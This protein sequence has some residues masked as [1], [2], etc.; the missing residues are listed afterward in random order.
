M[1]IAH[2]PIHPNSEWKNT[3]QDPLAA[4]REIR[5]TGITLREHYAGLALQGLLASPAAESDGWSWRTGSIAG[6]A[7]LFADE[8][9]AELEKR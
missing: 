7:V 5:H 1:S 6:D 4:P 2:K 3:S 9:I 8:L